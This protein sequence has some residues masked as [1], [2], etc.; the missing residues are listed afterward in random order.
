MY[1]RLPLLYVDIKMPN[2]FSS[3]Y[4]WLPEGIRHGLRQPASKSLREKDSQGSCHCWA[5]FNDQ[6]EKLPS[7]FDYE[8]EFYILPVATTPM[9]NTGAGSQK[10]FRKRICID[11]SEDCLVIGCLL[12]DKRMTGK[13]SGC[14][15]GEQEPLRFLQLKSK[16]QQL[17]SFKRF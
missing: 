2:I 15:G 14:R 10:T 13:P 8:C 9:M 7:Q 11:K 5:S 12:K 6:E 1:K 16:R 17:G 4:R 3:L